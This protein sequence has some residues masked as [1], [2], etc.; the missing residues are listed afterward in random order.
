MQSLMH[1]VFANAIK[2]AV[3]VAAANDGVSTDAINRIFDAIDKIP[4][5]PYCYPFPTCCSPEVRPTTNAGSGTRKPC[6]RYQRHGKCKYGD[7]CFF[8]HL[9]P[10]VEQ[11]AIATPAPSDEE[12]VT[13]GDAD[14]A[15]ALPMQTN[16]V[17][18]DFVVRS[19]DALSRDDS[20][21]SLCEECIMEPRDV[22]SLGYP[23]A[24][25]SEDIAG[26]RSDAQA[27]GVA[28]VL[29]RTPAQLFEHKCADPFTS[30]TEQGR[31]P[32]SLDNE[33]EK[34]DDGDA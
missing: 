11:F 18:D 12:S 16:S 30:A 10:D 9:S 34:K 21:A 23:Q 7:N 28:I 1:L 6:R 4:P 29:A 26:E 8:K 13:T 20:N 2:A 33:G 17:P 14:E 32:Q 19:H 5:A 22:H 25:R 31:S 3:A 27:F 24:S 15:V